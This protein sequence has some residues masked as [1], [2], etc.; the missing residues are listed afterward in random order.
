MNHIT[1][2]PNNNG[3]EQVNTIAGL[4]NTLLSFLSI[5]HNT[6][7]QETQET[8]RAVQS[9]MQETFATDQGQTMIQ[10][11]VEA[12]SC[13]MQQFAVPAGQELQIISVPVGYTIVPVQYVAGTADNPSGYDTDKLS[14]GDLHK[15]NNNDAQVSISVRLKN[16]LLRKFHLVPTAHSLPICS[17]SGL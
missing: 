4:T 12:G 1:P 11:P 5:V 3:N 13:A 7:L 2:D 6:T 8:D 16:Y 10:N 9:I 14:A 17:I 15:N